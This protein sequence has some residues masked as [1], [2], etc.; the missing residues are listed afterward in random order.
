MDSTDTLQLLAR[1]GV[2]QIGG[3][4]VKSFTALQ[5]TNDLPGVTRSFNACA[6]LVWLANF[7]DGSCAIIKTIVP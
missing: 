7:T 2:T 1:Q 6:T 5:D 3:K 4:T